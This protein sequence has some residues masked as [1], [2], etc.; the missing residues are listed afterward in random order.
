MRMAL[1]ELA[2]VGVTVEAHGE[3]VEQLDRSRAVTHP[4]G[5]LA[6]ELL[7]ELTVDRLDGTGRVGTPARPVDGLVP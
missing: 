1:G 2:V 7:G 6:D 4:V 3:E 5:A